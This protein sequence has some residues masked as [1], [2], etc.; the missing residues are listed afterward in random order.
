MQGL[1]QKK[2]TKELQQEPYQRK[3]I[4]ILPLESLAIKGLQEISR[5]RTFE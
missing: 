5:Y 2:Q 3:H 4:F 1:C